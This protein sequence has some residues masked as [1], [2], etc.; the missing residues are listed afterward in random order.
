MGCKTCPF[1]HDHR[2]RRRRSCA[3]ALSLDALARCRCL[4]PSFA[5]PHFP[6]LVQPR[7]S[8]PTTP[9]S[10]ACASGP[11]M[12][13]LC[14]PSGS[15][16]ATTASATPPNWKTAPQA[17]L[18][19]ASGEG[20]WR[21][22]LNVAPRPR[23]G[24]ARLGARCSFGGNREPCWLHHRRCT[25]PSRLHAAVAAAASRCRRGGDTPVVS[26]L[27]YNSD[28]HCVILYLRFQI[29][30]PSKRRFEI[31]LDVFRPK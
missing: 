11:F 25:A 5:G 14:S 23:E 26:P 21:V 13:G 12:S 4:V 16:T 1:R 6:Q 2:R 20:R 28:L 30:G 24:A 29:L 27:P 10:A 17:A 31:V 7:T 15:T 19:R 3:P 9:F 22:G 18:H 8:S